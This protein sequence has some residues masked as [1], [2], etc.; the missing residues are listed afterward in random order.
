M[1]GRQVFFT[2]GDEHY[3]GEVRGNVMTGTRT[4]LARGARRE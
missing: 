2:L 4:E 1:H 3:V